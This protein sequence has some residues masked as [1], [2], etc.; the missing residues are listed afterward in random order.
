MADVKPLVFTSGNEFR[1]EILP[2]D[3][4]SLP[5]LVMSGD[6]DMGT[7]NQINNLADG[8]ANTDAITLQQ[9]LAATA[10]RDAKDNAVAL[11]DTNQALTGLPTIDGVSP[12]AGQRVLLTGQTAPAENGLWE[13]AAGAWTRPSD[14]ATGSSAEGAFVCITAGTTYEAS[15]WVAVSDA[16]ADVVDTNDPLFTQQPTSLTPGDGIDITGTVVSVDLSAIPGLFFNAGELEVLLD[17]A[18]LNL[19]AAG[20]SV[21]GVPLNF[22][23]DGV[24][25]SSNVTGANINALT[26]GVS[27]ADSLHTH[28]NVESA[29]E[30]RESLTSHAAIN[31]GDP[32]EWGGTVD[33][34]RQA[35]AANN[36]EVDAIGV[37]V[38][39]AAGAG[40]SVDVV[41]LGIAEGVISGATVG[42]RYFLAAGGGL[43][44]GAGGFTAGQ[45]IVFM[46]TAKNATDLE[47]KP[48]YIGR[49]N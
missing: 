5:G 29:R 26:D 12:T 9:L 24:A 20:L 14:F 28:G 45:H 34:V 19:A 43:V 10:A 22:T 23:I 32:V 48:Q 3:R 8:T 31:L 46:G 18:T 35:N 36:A 27:N 13:V 30:V 49:K 40:L 6:V 16:P 33:R 42:D 11:A 37:A 25:T 47:V 4:L 2:A 17:G 44:Q 7:T 21:A 39:A 1:E 38:T 15:C 41:R